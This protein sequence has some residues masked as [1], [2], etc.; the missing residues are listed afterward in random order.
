MKKRIIK[1]MTQLIASK[2]NNV[3]VME[4]YLNKKG[5]KCICYLYDIHFL[6]GGYDEENEYN[7]DYN[8]RIITH[9]N[10]VDVA[11]DDYI[12]NAIS[13]VFPDD[14]KYI[15][16]DEAM[17]ATDSKKCQDY[18]YKGFIKELTNIVTENNILVY[19]SKD[20]LSLHKCPVGKYMFVYNVNTDDLI[21]EIVSLVAKEKVSK[22]LVSK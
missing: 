10:Q 20:M 5:E 6:G 12:S 9:S 3:D 7:K 22:V 17:N 1:A 13:K 15:A 8:L 4:I 19:P 21:L 14:N 16:I 11:L 18:T 2:Y